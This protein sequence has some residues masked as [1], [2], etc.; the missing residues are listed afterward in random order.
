MTPC[1]IFSDILAQKLGDFDPEPPASSAHAWRQPSPGPTVVFFDPR[2]YG[3]TVA[4]RWMPGTAS[5][6]PCVRPFVRP[7]PPVRPRRILTPTQQQAL[8]DLVRHGATLGVDFTD[9]E[10]RSAFRALARRYHP[11]RHPESEALEQARLSR[12][13][14]SLTDAYR[15]LIAASTDAVC[16]AA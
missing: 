9:G 1:G 10:L 6:E 15:H 5:H 8:E 4:P 7:A 2:F 13:F 16:M 11:D 12:T 3:A 14:A